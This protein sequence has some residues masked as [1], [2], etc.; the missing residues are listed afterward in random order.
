M[1]KA[2]FFDLDGTLVDSV[3]DLSIALNDSFKIAGLNTHSEDTIRSWVGNGVDRLLHRAL[4]NSVD[5]DAPE[6]DFIHIKSIF[7][8]GYEQQSGKQS[9][10]YPGVLETLEYL[11]DQQIQMACITNKSRCF[12]LPLLEKMGI[13]KFFPVVVCGDD[14]ANKKPHPEPLVF[15]ARHFQLKA[16]QCL[17]V[18][19]SKSD[20]LAANGAKMDVFCVDYGYSQ[21]VNLAAMDIT[22]MISK[23]PE[24]TQVCRPPVQ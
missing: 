2:I 13:A 7:Y 4:T 8:K 24:I 18:G 19:D 11:S 9:K 16:N 14:L 17:M 21:G 12:T 22:K 6:A 15:A 10:L 23:F 1:L 20:V 3:A 5:Q